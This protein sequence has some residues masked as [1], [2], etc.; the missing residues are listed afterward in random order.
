VDADVYCFQEFYHQQSPSTFKTRDTMLTVLKTKNYHERYTHEMTGQ[1]FFGLATFTSLPILNKG[2]IE[3]KND[4]N[5]YCI[6]TDLLK[7]R[8]TIR[9]FNAHIG[10]I[11]LAGEDLNLIKNI[12]SCIVEASR[13]YSTMIFDNIE[14]SF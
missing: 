4:A 2:G 13:K 10:S 3:F 9:I 8:D 1:R 11:R 14:D 7:N 12:K 5:N 6:Y